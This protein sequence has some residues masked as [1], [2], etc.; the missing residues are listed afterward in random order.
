MTGE[1]R[2]MIRSGS[3]QGITN[4]RAA[5]ARMVAPPVPAGRREREGG[6]ERKVSGRGR[7]SEKEAA[8]VTAH[9]LPA[10]GDRGRPR[11]AAAESIEDR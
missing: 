3:G 5:V 6:H 11:R 10:A 2:F 1:I 8:A 9:S 7:A 4:G